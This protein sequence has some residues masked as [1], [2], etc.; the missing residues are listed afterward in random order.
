MHTISLKRL[1]ASLLT[2]LAP[3]YALSM[4]AQ[5]TVASNLPV[6]PLFGSQLVPA[7]SQ[8]TPSPLL[9][10]NTLLSSVQP[11]SSS[12]DG[13]QA[14]SPSAPSDTPQQPE[15]STPAQASQPS[16]EPYSP[17]QTKRI[18][19]VVPN[20]RAVSADQKLPPQSVKDKFV[21][22]SQDSLDYS[23]TVIPALLAGYDLGRNSVPQFGHG[24]VAFGRYIWHTTVDQTVE[25]YMVEF[26]V[27]SLTHEDTRYYTLGHG[28]F[29][30]RTGYALS[31]AF[32][33]RSDSGHDTFN[34]SEI[35]GAGASAGISNLYYP[36]AQR[37]LS[38]TANGWALDVGLD[39]AT[40]VLKEFWP[41]IDH[42]FFH[43]K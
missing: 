42:K 12:V 8:P 37:T 14:A 24:G 22:A 13:T 20:F 16:S 19:G 7:G 32:V 30:R 28:G 31:R 35:V 41:D 5:Q 25:N 10:P 23:S 18:L 34:I 15:T 43:D 17:Q 11:F 27:P 3:L 29:Y 1:A 40:F 26:I 6:S 21:T 36:S 33:T 4:N 2:A 39:A 38:N 9:T